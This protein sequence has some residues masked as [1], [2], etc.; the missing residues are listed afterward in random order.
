MDMAEMDR[1]A[2]LWRKIGELKAL[3]NPEGYIAKSLG[4]PPEQRLDEIWKL[5]Q[6][7]QP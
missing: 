4:E 1:I 7:I 6:T 2:F 3:A 5:L